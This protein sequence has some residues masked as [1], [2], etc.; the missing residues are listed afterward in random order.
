MAD[1]V[2]AEG[3]VSSRIDTSVP[4]SARIWNYWLGGK[5]YYDAD[6]AAGDA[7]QEVFP[8]IELLARASR[9]FLARS[10]RYLTAEA[11]IRQFL[12]V[13]TGLPTANNTHQVAQRIAPESRVVYVDHDPLVLAHARALLTSTPEGATAYIDADLR[14]PDTVLAEAARTLDLDRPVGLIFSG[15]LGH[16]PDHHEARAIVRRLMDALASG[17]HLSLNDGTDTYEA[18]NRAQASYNDSGAIPYVLRP[19]EQ[20]AAFFDGLEMV[21]PGLVPCPYWR[22]EQEPS[23]DPAEEVN[24]GAVG[25]K[26]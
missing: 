12:D 13:G 3:E 25:R 19:V 24:Y 16:I 18:A 9:G 2:P 6:R 8:G 1:D 15:T 23:G 20:I 5:D 17:S 7:Y 14:D 4:H 26:P 10:I 11:G 21:E 22:P